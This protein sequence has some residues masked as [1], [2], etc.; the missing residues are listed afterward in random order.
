M[1]AIHYLAKRRNNF[2]DT[3]TIGTFMTL[4]LEREWFVAVIVI[5]VGAGIS[6][7]VETMSS[8]ADHH[9]KAK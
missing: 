1:G 5:F 8:H 6:A 9:G 4:T 7:A 2:I 3:M